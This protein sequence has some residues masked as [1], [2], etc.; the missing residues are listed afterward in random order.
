MMDRDWRRARPAH[1]ATKALK[2]DMHV[3]LDADV[4]GWFKACR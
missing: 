3:R 1:P 2:V 4:P